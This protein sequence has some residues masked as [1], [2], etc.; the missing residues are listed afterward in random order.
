MNGP[1]SSSLFPESVVYAAPMNDRRAACYGFALALSLVLGGEGSGLAADSASVPPS[2]G[3]AS[4]PRLAFTKYTLPNGLEVI[5]HRETSLPLVAVNLWYHVGPVNEPKGRS[6]FAHL[7]EH[8]MFEGSRHV[9]GRFDELLESAGATNVNGTT[10]WDRTNYFE[11]VPRESLELALWIESDR[12]AYL[13]DSLNAESL[14]LVKRVVLNERHQNYV[15]APYGPSTLALYDALFPLGHPYHGAVIGSGADIRA[16]TLQEV[17][18]F[19]LSY[20]SPGNATLALAGDFDPASARALIERYFGSLPR[21]PLPALRGAAQVV[22]PSPRRLVVK[23]P[24]DLGRVTLAW[25]VPPAF[26]A[27]EAALEL[28][29]TIL[30][31]GKTTRLYQEL[32][33]EQRLASEVAAYLDSN[34]VCSV[35]L[36]MATAA[37]GIAPEQLERATVGVVS[38]LAEQPPQS[39]ELERA[40]RRLLVDLNRELELLND[41][42]GESGRAGLLQRYNHYLGSPEFLEEYLARIQAVDAPRV[43]QAARTYLGLAKRTTILTKPQARSEEP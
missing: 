9:R 35:L 24:V 30:D 6:G 13:L 3:S 8:L 18:D 39:A 22:A 2:R 36:V 38:A 21:R 20:Y 41:S 34:Q 10:S 32:V 40:R 33:V 43:Q 31:G 4:L 28:L 11:T 16:A 23:E 42:G 26:S 15:L 37:R 5:L 29:A 25:I 17:K 7:F 12:M 1:R 27:D 19:Y 14:E